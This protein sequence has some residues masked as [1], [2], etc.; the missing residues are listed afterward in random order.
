VTKSNYRYFFTSE[1]SGN[2][3]S[4][5]FRLYKHTSITESSLPDLPVLYHTHKGR[6]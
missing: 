4:S 3:F 6:S 1:T 5:I 2:S